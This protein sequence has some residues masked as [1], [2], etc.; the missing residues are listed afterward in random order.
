MTIWIPVNLNPKLPKYKALAEAITQAVDDGTLKPGAKLPTQR[1]LA[2][3]LGVTVGTVTRAYAEA[4]KQLLIESRVG[5][6]TYVKSA[7]ADGFNSTTGDS[8]AATIDLSFSFALDV[9]QNAM[10]ANQLSQLSNQPNRLKQL[11]QYQIGEAS[12]A[13]L[14]AGIKWLSMS[15]VQTP[16]R[17]NLL[18]TYGGQHGFYCATTAIC[19]ARDT[20][21]SPGLTYPGFSQLAQQ[22]GLRHI[23]LISDEFGVTVESLKLACQRYRPRL[24]YLNTRTNNPSCEQMNQAR[25]DALAEVLRE[26]Q[27]MVIE[28]DVQGC[29]LDSTLPSFINSY[30]DITCYV[31]STS[32][33]L[34]GGLRVGYVLSPPHLVRPIA[35]ALRASCWI[36]APLMVEI[37][38]HW[39][40]DG[41]AERIIELQR[42]ELSARHRA[43]AEALNKH[44]Y[45]ACE[46]GFNVW[47]HLP[48][49][50][51]AQE[52]CQSL[53]RQKVL[54]KPSTAFA[55]G[56]FDSGQAIRFCLGGD[57]SRA[58]LRQATAI[59]ASELEQ[60]AAE[61]DLSH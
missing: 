51:R 41:T 5:S 16:N 59:I 11:L 7:T 34:A 23:G 49:A 6:G 26:H 29:L 61:F 22:M 55:V 42:W 4:E 8:D 15:G 44:T 46:H 2:D 33:A 37:A 20:V 53:A 60:P 32:K 24:L 14:E 57:T 52:F 28:D 3:E 36:P 58:D 10:L 56:H 39:I 38:S 31:T 1:F 48:P 45:A 12:K 30:R 47:L 18:I 35:A 9:K 43:V 27:V 25:I 17:D 13:H 40:N 19:K 54:A 50:R 21:L